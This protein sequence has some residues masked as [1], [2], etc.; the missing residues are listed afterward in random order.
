M[1]GRDGH[2]VVGDGEGSRGRV[3]VGAWRGLNHHPHQPRIRAGSVRYE[4]RVRAPVFACLKV[5]FVRFGY[6]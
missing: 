2:R 1:Q 6:V 4:V 5:R 3:G